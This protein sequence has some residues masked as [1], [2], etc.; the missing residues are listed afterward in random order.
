M[1]KKKTDPVRDEQLRTMI[2]A[3][4]R[5]EAMR[6]QCLID[7]AGRDM[8]VSALAEPDEEFVIRV[9]RVDGSV[10]LT[11]T[12]RHDPSFLLFTGGGLLADVMP[13]RSLRAIVDLFEGQ[14]ELLGDTATSVDRDRQRSAG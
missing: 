8:P 6:L 7:H 5:A 9:A 14:P 3:G 1:M 12:I 13:D 10:L 11:S 4:A 2:A